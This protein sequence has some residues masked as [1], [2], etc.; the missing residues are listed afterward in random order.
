MSLGGARAACVDPRPALQA[1]GE[2]ER[3]LARLSDAKRVAILLAK[4]EG[5]SCDEIAEALQI[6]VGTVWTRLHAARRELRAALGDEAG[7]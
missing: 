6:P 7:S 3:A 4:V 5:L 1:R 2:V